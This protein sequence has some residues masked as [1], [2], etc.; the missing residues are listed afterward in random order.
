MKEYEE[1]LE[2]QVV[3]A[4]QQDMK[5]NISSFFGFATKYIPLL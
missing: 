3:S 1:D 5:H 2:E 4:S